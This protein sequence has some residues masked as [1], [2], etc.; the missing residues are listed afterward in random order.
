LRQPG[1]LPHH[2]QAVAQG[3]P[4]IAAGQGWQAPQLQ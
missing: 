3:M 4:K 2:A 1:F